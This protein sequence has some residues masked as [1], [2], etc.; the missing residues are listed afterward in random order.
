MPR[1]LCGLEH[2]RRS[3]ARADL[4]AKDHPQSRSRRIQQTDGTIGRHE[5]NRQVRTAETSETAFPSI[6]ITQYKL[7][8]TQRSRRSKRVELNSNDDLIR[9]V[10]PPPYR[11]THAMSETDANETLSTTTNSATAHDSTFHSPTEHRRRVPG[12]ESAMDLCRYNQR[13]GNKPAP[14]CNIRA[15]AIPQ[16]LSSAFYLKGTA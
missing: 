14:T 11:R 4:E 8:T 3:G 15:I 16:Q 2:H 12:H 5:R 10:A 1:K 6:W 7:P 13:F 9:F